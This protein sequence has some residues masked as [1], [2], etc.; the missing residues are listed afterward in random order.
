MLASLCRNSIKPFLD[1]NQPVLERTKGLCSK[2]THPMVMYK[3]GVT[4]Y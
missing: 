3:L 2:P 4:N 1:P